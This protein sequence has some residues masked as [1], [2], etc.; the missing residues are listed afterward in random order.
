MFKSIKQML[1]NECPHC[2]KGRVFEKSNNLFSIQFPK[3]QVSCDHCHSKYQKEPGFF[4]GAM[5]VSY[6][7][8]VAE[9]LCTY[10][11][12]RPFFEKAL[13]LRVIPIIALVIVL[14]TFFN[15]RM[16]KMIWIYMF[17]NYSR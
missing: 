13:D 2:H 14:L 1:N 5:Y 11:L 7:L 6:G 10:I 8:T 12:T 17:K 16:S 4:I 15:I 3:M 9:A